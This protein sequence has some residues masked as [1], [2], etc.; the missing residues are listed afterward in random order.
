MSIIVFGVCILLNVQN[1]YAGENRN[2]ILTY[3]TDIKCEIQNVSRQLY[4]G[5]I[6]EDEFQ[7]RI[8]LL[9]INVNKI[10]LAEKIDN[11]ISGEIVFYSYYDEF[12][13]NQFGANAYEIA[14]F[15]KYP[16]KAAKAITCASQASDMAERLWKSWSLWQGN[17][18][19][20]RHAYWSALMTIHIDKDFAYKESYAHEGYELGTYSKIKD[21]DTKMD[22]ENN[23]R[24]RD[25]GDIYAASSF[26]DREVAACI[27]QSVLSGKL[28]RIRKKTTSSN[29]DKKFYDDYG[30]KT[31][32]MTY[33]IQTNKGGLK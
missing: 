29:Y 4:R 15:K 6:S 17:G 19:A 24:G 5:E 28:V 3:Y 20:F 14:L 2:S 13:K 21:I 7:K 22:L 18:D 9:E 10:M 26:N 1:A 31:I 8:E 32:K 16:G 12:A 25:L 30:E 11:K 27:L 23:H 33:F